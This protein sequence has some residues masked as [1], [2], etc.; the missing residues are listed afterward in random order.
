MAVSTD[1]AWRASTDGRNR[2]MPAL[3][4]VRV[5]L[6]YGM[7]L[8]PV[9]WSKWKRLD[10]PE[11]PK[12]ALTK[13]K[14]RGAAHFAVRPSTRRACSSATAAMLLGTSGASIHRCM[15]CRRANGIAPRASL[16]ALLDRASRAGFDCTAPSP[17]CTAVWV[18]AARMRIVAAVAA[19]ALAA[20]AAVVAAVVPAAAVRERASTR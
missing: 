4:A 18:T 8:T 9:A 10:Q 14:S 20:A 3:A 12:L 16:S 7:R 6:V 5:L 11:P 17:I 2:A 1:S 19:A 15:P 13:T